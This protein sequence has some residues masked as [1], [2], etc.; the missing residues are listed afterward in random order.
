MSMGD[1]MFGVESEAL[2]VEGMWG[3]LGAVVIFED[4]SRGV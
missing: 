4:W 2:V 1:V 3:K